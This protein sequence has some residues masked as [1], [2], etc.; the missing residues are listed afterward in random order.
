MR[1]LLT[2]RRRK[3]VNIGGKGNI[4]KINSLGQMPSRGNLYQSVFVSSLLLDFNMC[5]TSENVSE[6]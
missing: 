4:R 2:T 1:F 5:D 3:I 6:D